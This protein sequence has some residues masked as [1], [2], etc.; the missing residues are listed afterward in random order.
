MKTEQLRKLI[1]LIVKESK[2]LNEGTQQQHTVKDL[3]R[4][5]KQEKNP[6]VRKAMGINPKQKSKKFF[7]GSGS[8][9]SIDKGT[10][11][12]VSDED[13]DYVEYVGPR[14]GEEP[15]TLRT[16]NGQEKFEYCNGKYPSGKT[17]IA[18]YAYRGDVCYG[19]NYFR[20]LFNLQESI[21]KKKI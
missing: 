9:K 20:K 1:K 14:Q 7:G 21:V 18:V 5:A 19:Y 15:F 10:L 11:K 3:E 16:R 8:K 2:N 12:E 17:D 6:Y 13:V 4:F